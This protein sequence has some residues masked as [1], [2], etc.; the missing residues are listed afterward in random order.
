MSIQIVYH[1]CRLKCGIINPNLPNNFPVIFRTSRELPGL[2][3]TEFCIDE[4]VVSYDGTAQNFNHRI[5][6][7]LRTKYRFGTLPRETMYVCTLGES[8]GEL[9]VY[10]I[11]Q[12]KRFLLFWWLW[13]DF[14]TRRRI[15][16]GRIA[17]SD[18]RQS[19]VLH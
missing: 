19:G 1:F 6:F 15:T 13:G 8:K 2:I 5:Q 12:A 10:E 3:L 7:S 17:A 14:A 11:T 18:G 9:I 4:S 16:V